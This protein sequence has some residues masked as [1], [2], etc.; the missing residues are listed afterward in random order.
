P[1]AIILA[2][3]AASAGLGLVPP[4]LVRE[5]VDRALPAHDGAHVN[6]LV[7][8]MIGAPLLAGLIGVWQ[9]YLVTVVGQGVMFDL[10]CRMYDRLIRQ[11]LRFFTTTRSGEIQSR[12][13]N[14]V[15]GVQGVVTGTMVALVTNTV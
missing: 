8:G 11:S 3:I 13:Q 2:C 5:L 6:W 15:G 1:S 4:L 14:D 12:L 9:N 10:R 7:A